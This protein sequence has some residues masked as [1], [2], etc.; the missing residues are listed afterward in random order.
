MHAENKPKNTVRK[1]LRARR[2]VKWSLVA[3]LLLLV[4]VF[5]GAP[6]VV[7]SGGFRKFLLAKINKS[8]EG[9]TDF[10]DLSMGWLKGVKV[11]DLSFDDSAG[12]VSVKVK[13][14]HTRPHYARLIG[15]N[16]S[17]GTTTIDQPRVEI[18]LKAK[19]LAAKPAA[20]QPSPVP[21]EAAGIAFVT[22][23]VINDGSVKVTD[24]H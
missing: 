18:S 10:A 7:S 20:P 3:V 9:H 13:K 19:P 24:A 22:D 6:A 23:V 11:E 1:K 16:L 14:I 8:V 2:I 5:L 21:V 4:V 15:G 12:Q 17:F